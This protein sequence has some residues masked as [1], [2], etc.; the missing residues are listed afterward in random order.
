MDKNQLHSLIRSFLSEDIGRGDLTTES[1]F[2]PSQTGTARLV[3]RESALRQ[4]QAWLQPRSS[5][6]RIRPSRPSGPW[7]TE[8]VSPE[9]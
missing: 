6:C 1:I 2:D 8:P 7:R 4:A 5:R 3:A 9:T